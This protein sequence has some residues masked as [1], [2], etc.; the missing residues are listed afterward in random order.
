VAEQTVTFASAGN[1]LAGTLTLPALP[2]PAPA[3]LLLPGSGPTDRDDNAK[4]LAIDLFPPLVT[5]LDEWGF[6]TFRYDKRGVGASGGSYWAT[7]FDD[8]LTDAV[9]AVTWL[10]QQPQVDASRIYVLGHSEGALLAGRLAAGAAP[11]AG[12]VLLAGSAKS[13]EQTLLW[14]G[15]QIIPTITG[16]SA[17][18]IR[19]LRI[20]P[21]K[22]QRKFIARVK[23]TTGDT[24]R[25]QL[26]KKVNAKW[27][28]E[29]IAYDPAAD[30]TAVRVPV[31]AITGAKD[32]QT[33][34]A[35]IDR[36][37]KLDPGDFEGHVIPDVTHLLRAEPG[38]PSLRTYKQQAQRP[39][40]PRVVDYLHAWLQRVNKP[41]TGYGSEE[42]DVGRTPVGSGAR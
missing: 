34:P 1:N 18:L 23:A 30:L 24:V 16:F 38:A 15:R 13:G 42:A 21:E 10:A 27:L 11:V 20:D 4:T 3:M 39:I 14:Q 28:R 31:L 7:G 33:D 26:V 35:D 25:V 37:A 2:G 32:L 41:G 9:A 29:F 5:A 12:A 8:R 6:A 40:D 17:R 22:Q 36:M 19:L